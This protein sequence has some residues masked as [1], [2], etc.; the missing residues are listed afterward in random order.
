VLQVR[1][2]NA[3]TTTDVYRLGWGAGIPHVPASSLRIVPTPAPRAIVAPTGDDRATVNVSLVSNVVSPFTV[4]ATNRLV[5]PAG[6]VSIPDPA[7][8]SFP[9]VAVPDAVAYCTDTGAADGADNVTAN[10]TVRDPTLPSTTVAFPIPTATPL[11]GSSLRITPTPVAWPSVAPDGD[12]SLTV[13]TSV[14]ST[15]VSP[16]TVTA[17]KRVVAPAV[18]VNVPDTAVKSLPAVAV[19]DAVAYCTDTVDVDC[20]DNV[21]G[22]TTTRDPALPSSTDAEPTL[23]TGRVVACTAGALTNETAQIKVAITTAR[24]LRDAMRRL[25]TL[26]RPLFTLPVNAVRLLRSR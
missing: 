2:S 7:V 11:D 12:D 3:N 17:T 9:A 18:N 5:A 1:F 10:H 22:S 15:V 23:T 16:V 13:N 25:H 6:N 26:P 20:A 24:N 4:T 8:K 19:P 14:A 21:T